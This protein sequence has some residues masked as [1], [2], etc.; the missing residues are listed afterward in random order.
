MCSFAKLCAK[1][2]ERDYGLSSFVLPK[3]SKRERE[4]E[5]KSVYVI[6]R[7]TKRKGQRNGFLFS[8]SKSSK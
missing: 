5:S 6:K 4:R 3:V 1:V 8:A 2:S 7:H